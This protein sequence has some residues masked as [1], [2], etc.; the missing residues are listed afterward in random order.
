MAE[1][2]MTPQERDE[3]LADVHVGILAIER[4]SKGPLA[5]PIWYQYEDGEILMGLSGN[6]LKATLLRS[7]GRATLTIQTET[8][9]YKY[10]MA[11]GPVTV[12]NEQRD[13]YEMASRYLGP[14]LGKWYAENNPSTAES[15][16]ARL[17]PEQWITCD[18]AKMTT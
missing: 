17:R 14:E 18:F 11:T 7:A 16:V 6:S 12:S 2:E 13:D 1:M 4:K 3:F 15:V 5:V 8:P 10:V 9:P